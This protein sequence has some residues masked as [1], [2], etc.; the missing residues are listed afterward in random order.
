MFSAYPSSPFRVRSQVVRLL[1]RPG[2]YSYSQYCPALIN[3][4]K[5]QGNSIHRL[6]IGLKT[7]EWSLVAGDLSCIRTYY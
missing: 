4:L 3:E 7:R 6:V 2:D 1:N 5:L